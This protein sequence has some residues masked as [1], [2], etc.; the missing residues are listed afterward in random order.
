[1]TLKCIREGAAYAG[2]LD[3]VYDIGLQVVERR[4]RI[5]RWIFH[6]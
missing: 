4:A 3:Y 2:Y 6:F 1:M 5:R